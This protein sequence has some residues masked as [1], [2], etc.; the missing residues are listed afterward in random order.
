MS[1]FTPAEISYLE[2]QLLARI[3]T[4]GPDGQ[5]HVVPVSFRY[6]QDTDTIDVS[7]HGFVGRK[8]YRDVQRHPLVA[9]VLDD[10]ASTDPWRPRGIEVRGMAA[11]LPTGGEAVGHGFDP[12]IFRIRPKRIISW[13]INDQNPRTSEARSVS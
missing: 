5:P 13:G 3:A 7:G 10:L 11:I 2:N 12:E 6:N 4:T 9:I 8:K 1:V